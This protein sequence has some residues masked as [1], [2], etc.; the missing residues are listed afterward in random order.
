[1]SQTVQAPLK[2]VV[3]YQIKGNTMNLQFASVIFGATL[4]TFFV[5]GSA[6][7]FLGS[8]TAQAQTRTQPTTLVG[9]A[10]TV[11][12]TESVKVTV[13]NNTSIPLYSAISGGS[14]VELAQQGSTT[15]IF[16]STPINV[17]VYP[18]SGEASLKF[19]TSVQGNIVTVQVSQTSG[20]TPGDGAI[21]IRPSGQVY[22]Y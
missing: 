2:F 5:F 1:V 20:D 6:I 14:S 15:F 11:N 16:G 7:P 10:G 12:P 4:G 17:F 13:K 18:A 19:D 22:I 3:F 9:T 8:E 21:N